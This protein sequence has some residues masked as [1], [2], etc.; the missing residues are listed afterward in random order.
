MNLVTMVYLLPI[1]YEKLMKDFTNKNSTLMT[2]MNMTSQ[3]NWLYCYN[4]DTT[5]PVGSDYVSMDWL[6]YSLVQLAIRDGLGEDIWLS[7]TLVAKGRQWDSYY[8]HEF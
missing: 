8:L 7:T 3:W 4:K 2:P 5:R 6:P 1:G